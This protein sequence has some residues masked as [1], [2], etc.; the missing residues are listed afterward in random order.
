MTYFRR[1]DGAT[2]SSEEALEADGLTVKSGYGVRGT[3]MRDG[4]TLQDSQTQY[5][6]RVS[7]AWCDGKAS[8][9]TERRSLPPRYR[10]NALSEYQDKLADSMK[11]AETSQAA[12]EDRIRLAWNRPK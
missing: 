12:Y 6:Q 4:A 5:E 10:P 3:L 7:R 8:P 2:V 1:S 9:S 11:A